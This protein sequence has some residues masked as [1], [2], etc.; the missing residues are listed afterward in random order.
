MFYAEIKPTTSQRMGMVS[1]T[2]PGTKIR[3]PDAD[4][5]PGIDPVGVPDLWV[6]R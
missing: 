1:A 4:D 3:L 5:L 6:K 2:H